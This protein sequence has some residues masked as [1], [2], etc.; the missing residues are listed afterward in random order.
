MEIERKFLISKDCL[1][2]DYTSY[3]CHRIEQG[4]LCTNPVVR[5]RRS[6]DDY[7]LT[8]KASGLLAREEYNLPL[9]AEAYAHLSQK[10]DGILIIKDRYVIPYENGLFIELDVFHDTYEGLF[11]AEVEFRTEE[12]ALAFTPPSWFGEDVTYSSLY[13]NSRL[14]NGKVSI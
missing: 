6:D 7:Y 4:Y 12:E 11:L 2:A 5:V 10:T 1:P 14:S 13:Q 8:Y 3:P 9:T